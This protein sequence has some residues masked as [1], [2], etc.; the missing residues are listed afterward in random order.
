MVSTI[1][2]GIF[3]TPLVARVRIYS[4]KNIF[5]CKPRI[6]THANQRGQELRGALSLANELAG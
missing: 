3:V 1:F 6:V 2:F 5:N 4:K